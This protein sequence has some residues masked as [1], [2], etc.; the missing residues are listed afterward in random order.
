LKLETDLE[1]EEAI[2]YFLCD[3][4]M[5][6]GEVKRYLATAAPPERDRMLGK[7]LR[8]ARDPD[9][10]YFTTP[11]EVAAR[12]ETL[13]RHLGRRLPFW[14]F[15]LAAWEKEGLLERQSASS[16]AGGDSGPLL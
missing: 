16:A 5:M 1:N 13:S 12:F 11:D 8:E 9:V 10:W 2:P 4:P 3:D 6:V 14:S 7:I 15:Q